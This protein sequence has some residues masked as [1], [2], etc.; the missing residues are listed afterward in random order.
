MRADVR[1]NDRRRA[2]RIAEDEVWKD[3]VE[4]I[5][6]VKIASNATLIVAPG[7]VVLIGQD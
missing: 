5:G 6:D 7:T 1:F 2:G 3:T 4:V